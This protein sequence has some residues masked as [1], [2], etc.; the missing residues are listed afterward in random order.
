MAGSGTRLTGSAVE[1]PFCGKITGYKAVP[2][3]EQAHSGYLQC[4]AA[5]QA[6]LDAALG[7]LATGASKERQSRSSEPKK[8]SG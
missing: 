2:G 3:S 8:L 1:C 4:I 7:G 5:L 6:R